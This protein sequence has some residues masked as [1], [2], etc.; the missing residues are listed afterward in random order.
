MKRRG[1]FFIALYL[2]FPSFSMADILVLKDGTRVNIGHEYWEE[3]EK[4]LVRKSGGTIGFGK[5]DVLRIERTPLSPK[6]EETSIPRKEF[7]AEVKVERERRTEG[8]IPITPDDYI[9][10]IIDIGERAREV[11]KIIRDIN[12]SEKDKLDQARGEIDILQKELLDLKDIPLDLSS[13]ESIISDEVQDSI[14]MLKEALDIGHSVIE[15]EERSQLD[16]GINVIDDA[17]SILSRNKERLMESMK[18]K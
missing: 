7:Q 13:R 11:F 9:S 8:I 10:K 6:I 5:R 12:P 17:Q 16:R 1:L 4:I 3:G 2:I 15:N 14:A 18:G